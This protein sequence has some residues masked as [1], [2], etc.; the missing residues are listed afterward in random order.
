MSKARELS[1]FYDRIEAALTDPD[2]ADEL[3]SRAD[4]CAMAQEIMKLRKKLDAALEGVDSQRRGIARAEDRESQALSDLESARTWARMWKAL[5]RR[6]AASA[7]ASPCG[8]GQPCRGCRRM[9]NG[10]EIFNLFYH[11]RRVVL[12]DSCVDDIIGRWVDEGRLR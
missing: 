3:T 12:C 7:K 2:A 1:A 4:I 11:E 6:Q 5:A 8:W 10:G 9:E